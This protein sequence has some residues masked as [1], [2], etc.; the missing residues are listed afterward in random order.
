[1]CNEWVQCLPRTVAQAEVLDE[2]M[3]ERGRGLDR[4]I[5][6]A[7]DTEAM[8]KRISGRFSCETCGAGYHDSF[9]TPAAE[10]FCDNCNGVRF[11]RRPDDKAET[12]R[13]RLEAYAA[14][15]APLLPY[16]RERG[17]LA[18]VNGMAEID[19]V[20]AQIEGALSA[21]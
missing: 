2:K 3:A 13:T 18:E 15:T 20:T 11:Q 1:M 10:G 5:E 9:H 21:A 6:I 14:Q 8:V 16:Y 12:V 17:L 7:V 19:D 4:V